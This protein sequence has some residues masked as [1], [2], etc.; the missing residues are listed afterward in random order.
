MQIFR[1]YKF[2]PFFLLYEPHFYHSKLN[3]KFL[4]NL[5][6]CIYCL[7]RKNWQYFNI[8][9]LGLKAFFK[10]PRSTTNLGHIS[11][12]GASTNFLPHAQFGVEAHFGV[13]YANFSAYTTLRHSFISGP[14]LTLDLKPQRP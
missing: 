1:T 13:F 7:V 14:K 9:C 12:I 8:S 11:I 4:I 10:L 3:V 5:E 6:Y 2:L